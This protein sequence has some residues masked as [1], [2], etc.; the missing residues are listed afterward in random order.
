MHPYRQKLEDSIYTDKELL[1]LFEDK[2]NLLKQG[3]SNFGDLNFNN[4]SLNEKLDY[5]NFKID[6]IETNNRIESLTSTIK[7]KQEYFDR[8]VSQIEKDII[9]VEKHYN[10][11]LSK[12]IELAKTDANVKMFVSKNDFKKIEESIELKIKVFKDFKKILGK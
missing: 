1:S 10:D 4:L 2:V 5:I 7:I 12:V 9:E 11:Y 3:I 8:F 6:L